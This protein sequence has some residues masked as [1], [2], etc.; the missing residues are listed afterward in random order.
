MENNQG[1][2]GGTNPEGM[3]VQKKGAI[4]L[5]FLLIK[6]PGS[7]WDVNRDDPKVSQELSKVAVA[8]DL[9]MEEIVAFI[10]QVSGKQEPVMEK[11]KQFEVALLIAKAAFV[12]MV[13]KEGFIGL[14]HDAPA[15]AEEIGIPASDFNKFLKEI[16]REQLDSLF[17]AE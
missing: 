16:F 2:A 6:L 9:T 1:R 7:P 12:S 15:L 14:S 17:P 3:E 13:E 8:A 4:A 10:E 11:Q 5:K